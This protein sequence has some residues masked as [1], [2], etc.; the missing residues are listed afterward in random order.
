MITTTR[1]AAVL[2]VLFLSV[3]AWAQLEEPEVSGSVW[4]IEAVT[5]VITGGTFLETRTDQGEPVKADSDAIWMFGGR[6]YLDYEYWGVDVSLQWGF[7]DMDLKADSAATVPSASD[8]NLML[9]DINFNWYITGNELADGRVKPF[10]TAGPGLAIFDSDFNQVSNEVAMDYNV[11]AGI[12][13]LLTEKGDIILNAMWRW[14]YFDSSH[15]G[16][17]GDIYRQEFSLGLG[18]RF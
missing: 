11:G 10:L 15:S 9:A 5:S 14:H 3:N 6:C 7:A 4:E 17:K 13:F 2:L 18:C 12:K 8:F 1:M 16:L